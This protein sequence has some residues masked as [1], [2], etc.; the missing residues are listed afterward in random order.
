MAYARLTNTQLMVE[1]VRRCRVRQI[2]NID[3]VAFAAA[4]PAAVILAL[5]G[6]MDLCEVRAAVNMLIVDEVICATCRVLTWT[7][8]TYRAN[9]E[10]GLL[11]QYHPELPFSTYQHFSPAGIPRLPRSKRVLGSSSLMVKGLYVIEDGLPAK[12]AKLLEKDGY[13]YPA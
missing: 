10:N 2:P 1:A 3:Y 5:D 4:D 7:E 8:N 6:L 13:I 11:R 9:H 12:V